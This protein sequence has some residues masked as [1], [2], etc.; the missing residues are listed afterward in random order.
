[1]LYDAMICYAISC[2]PMLLVWDET[3]SFTSLMTVS[4]SSSLTCILCCV[5]ISVNTISSYYSYNITAHIIAINEHRA[6]GDGKGG[7]KK[8]GK[9]G[10]EQPSI[11]WGARMAD[12][13]RY[14]SLTICYL[15]LHTN[16]DSDISLS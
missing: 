10:E 1:M 13:K 11:D 5:I 12:M 3:M 15:N 6:E 16:N 9:K 14:E 7:A 2:Y 4:T 8:G